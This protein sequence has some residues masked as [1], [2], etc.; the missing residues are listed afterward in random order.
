MPLTIFCCNWMPLIVVSN[1][2]MPTID[3]PR[4]VLPTGSQRPES[5]EEMVMSH[6]DEKGEIN[7]DKYNLFGSIRVGSDDIDYDC[8]TNKL[9]WLRSQII[10]VDAEFKSPFGRRHITYSDYTAS[11]RFL[12]FV[13]D[14][15]ERDALPFYG[16]FV[17]ARKY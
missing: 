3:P 5:G 4:P 2:S 11:G 9:K 10:G 17:V 7:G 8:G 13:E 12:R 6:L 16:E 1:P 15:L 14:W